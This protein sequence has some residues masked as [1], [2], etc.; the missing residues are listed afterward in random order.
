MFDYRQLTINRI[1]LYLFAPFRFPFFDFPLGYLRQWCVAK[2]PISCSANKKIPTMLLIVTNSKNVTAD[3]LSATLH[4]NSVKFLRFDTDVVLS[5]TRLYFDGRTPAIYLNGSQYRAEDFSN[6]WYR[7]P[8]HLQHPQYDGSPEAKFLLQEW[9]EAFEG[10]FAG[11]KK[12]RWMNHPSSN[13]AASHKIDQLAR[14]KSL[15][16]SAPDTLVT[17][18]ATQLQKFYRKPMARLSSNLSQ[19]DILSVSSH[20]GI[21]RSLR[22]W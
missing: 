2:I 20:I 19:A 11:I 7:R 4:Q 21:H 14:A 8:E 22:T 13:V 17:H 5:Q 12:A 10:F 6:V 3:Y 18:D 16:F 9:S 1:W 15:G